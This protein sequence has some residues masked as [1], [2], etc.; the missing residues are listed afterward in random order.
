MWYYLNT[1]IEPAN[2]GEVREESLNKQVELSVD[3]VKV[4][5][6]LKVGWHRERKIAPANLSIE[7]SLERR[8]FIWKLFQNY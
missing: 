3:H 5:T 4:L 6:K 8:F 7:I 2:T 1:A